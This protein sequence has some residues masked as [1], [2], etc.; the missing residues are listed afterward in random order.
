MAQI[1]INVFRLP[2]RPVWNQVDWT[3]ARGAYIFVSE[4]DTSNT[5]RFIHQVGRRLSA[6][7]LYHFNNAD[8]ILGNLVHGS[9]RRLGRSIRNVL[10]GHYT[11]PYQQS[12]D[13][14]IGPGGFVPVNLPPTIAARDAFLTRLEQHLSDYDLQHGTM[15]TPISGADKARLRLIWTRIIQHVND[16]YADY[17]PN[18]ISLAG[19][20]ATYQMFQRPRNRLK[21]LNSW[22]IP[23]YDDIQLGE[24]PQK[25]LTYLTDY[26][27]T[28]RLMDPGFNLESVTI[29]I[30]QL[31]AGFQ[32]HNPLDISRRSAMVVSPDYRTNNGIVNWLRDFIEFMSHSAG[33]FDETTF[34]YQLFNRFNPNSYPRAHELWNMIEDLFN[35][36]DIR[37]SYLYVLNSV[38]TVRELNAPDL[39][40]VTRHVMNQ[41]PMP[42]VYDDDEEPPQRVRIDPRHPPLNVQPRPAPIP[43]VPV[44]MRPNRA[45]T[46]AAVPAAAPAPRHSPVPGPSTADDDRPPSPV[47]GPSGVTVT[48]PR[49][50]RVRRPPARYADSAP[51]PPPR[52]RR[53]PAAAAAAP[54]PRQS[55]RARRAPVRYSPPL[56]KPKPKRRRRR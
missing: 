24:V 28:L 3:P 14:A 2:P 53:P 26:Q 13:I 27:S 8:G 52:Q 30:Y 9:F 44:D 51:P 6:V 36:Q 43:R 48:A 4:R 33:M 37:H 31:K 55:L 38:Y 22:V 41:F 10:G 40:A 56:I 11:I 7:G 18:D 1:P 12:I 50:Q 20:S 39:N 32:R 25:V 19:N 16:I 49:P 15:Y 45:P 46:R 23:V 34:D 29:Y 17:V 42:P 47:A 54:V 35:T 21:L 5:T